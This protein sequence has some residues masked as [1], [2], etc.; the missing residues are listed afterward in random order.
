[1]FANFHATLVK[2]SAHRSCSTLGETNNKYFLCTCSR[3]D[4]SMFAARGWSGKGS[5]VEVEGKEEEEKK[6]ENG[7]E[8]E[9]HGGRRRKGEG[10]GERGG[11]DKE[12]PRD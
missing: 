2:E 11:R 7:K 6:K 4:W 1:M 5:C 3:G 12:L 10:G 8:G 9:L